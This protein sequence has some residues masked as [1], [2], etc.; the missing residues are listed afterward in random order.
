M[1][2]ARQDK[3]KLLIAT[4]IFPPDIGGPATY[5]STLLKELPERGFDIKVITYADDAGLEGQKSKVKSQNDNSKLKIEEKI[6]RISRKHNVLFR[7]FKYF[8]AIF[9]S[10]DWADIVYVQGPVSEGIPTWLACKLRGKKYI[11]K[12]V[13]DYAWESYQNRFKIYD[14]RFKIK[15]FISP[16]EFQNTK[17]DLKTELLRWLER[18]VAK[19]AAKI[20]TPSEYLKKI[21]LKWGVSDGKIRVIYNSSPRIEKIISKQEARSDLKLDGKIILSVGRMVPWKGFDA[22]VEIMSELLKIDPGLKLIIIGDGPEYNNLRF[23]IE[24]LRLKDKIILTGSIP[25]DQVMK[26]MAAAD[27]FVLNTGYEGLSHVIIE[28]MQLGLPVITTLV[29]GNPE[30]IINGGNGILI[31]YGDNQDLLKAIITLMTND[32][33]LEEADKF[34]KEILKKLTKEIMIIE[35]IKELERIY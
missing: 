10:L 31:P 22:L 32:Y 11:L 1:E 27:M 7:Y 24:D 33:K 12:V 19:N 4:G 13:G 18:K 20:I 15:K 6:K 35:L 16:E 5:V 9:K 23:K 25:K 3:K 30:L 34:N 17:L 8:L 21:V 14:L 29:G 2:Q 26:Y 28:A